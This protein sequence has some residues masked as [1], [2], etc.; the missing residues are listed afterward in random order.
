MPEDYAGLLAM[1]LDEG[2]RVGA[3]AAV[4]DDVERVTGHAPRSLDEYVA[5]AWA[6]PAA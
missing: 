5:E 4:T 6:R 3:G 1:L 2:L